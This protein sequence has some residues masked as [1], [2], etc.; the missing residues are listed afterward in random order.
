[1]ASVISNGLGANQNNVGLVGGGHPQ[2]VEAAFAWG[3]SINEWHQHLNFL[4]WPEVLHQFA[5]VAS[6]GPQLE[7]CR[8]FHEHL[9]DDNEG[10]ETEDARS[11]LWFGA[12]VASVVD[13]MQGK[14]SG[15]SHRCRYCL[16]H[17]IVKYATFHVL[18]CSWKEVMG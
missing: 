14:G 16:T 11:T 1:M 6:F 3:F 17:G 10:Q 4:K 7:K 18:S 13:K 8:S 12:M 2:L 9:R 15:H 5:L